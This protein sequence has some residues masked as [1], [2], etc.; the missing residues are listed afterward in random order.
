MEGNRK[1]QIFQ[2]FLSYCIVVPLTL[3]TCACFATKPVIKVAIADN[4]APFYFQDKGGNFKGISV[5]ITYSILRKMGYTMSITQYPSMKMML[6]EIELGKQD[7]N[8]NLTATPEREKIAIFTQEPHIFETQNLIV[9]ADSNIQYAGALDQ[10]KSYRLGII[11]G[12]TYGQKFDNYNDINR[13]YINNSTQQLRNLLS[14]RFDIA[15]NNPQFFKTLASEVK[16]SNAFK[17]LTPEVHSLPVT[18]AVSKR[19]PDAI[20][21]VNLLNEHVRTFKSS[22]A[23][24]QLLKKYGFS[25]RSI[26]RDLP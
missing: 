5:E 16:T 9:R 26:S 14:G 3:F 15:V 7:M 12:W 11:F 8:I 23:Y 25:T 21:F 24:V 13:V 10:L 6:K 22:T 19:F 4:Y 2:R 20:S 18:I 1:S 17:I